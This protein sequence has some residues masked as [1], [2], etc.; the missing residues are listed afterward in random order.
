MIRLWEQGAYV[1][2]GRSI[3]PAREAEAENSHWRDADGQPLTSLSR[4]NSA[5]RTMAARILYSHDVNDYSESPFLHLR[6]DCLTSHDI[7]Y[8]SI[9]QT[10]RAIAGPD[11]P[12]FPVPYILSNCHNSLC[13]VGGTINADD[14]AFGLSAAKRY[15]AVFVPPHMAVIH[16]YIRETMAGCGKMILG[17]DS[18]TRYG[19]MGTLGVGEGGGELVK[20][21]LNRTYDIPI[22]EVIGVCL[23]GSPRPGTG[24][25][26]VA[27]TLIKAVFENGYV[28][29]KILEF[30]GDGIRN[31]S[32]DFRNAIDVMTTETACLSSIW[33]TDETVREYYVIHGREN[34]YKAM[35][36]GEAAYYN[37]LIEV[38]LSDI[39][40]MIALPF[41]PSHVYTIDELSRNAA[42]IASGEGFSLSAHM[43]NGR[44]CFNQGVIAG[45]AG[46]LYDN[47]RA[48]A[49]ILDSVSGTGQ[50]PLNIYPASQPIYISLAEN[51]VIAKLA[52]AGA[53]IKTAFCGPCFGAGDIPAHD[54]LSARHTTRNF[55]HREGSKPNDGQRAF[56]ALMDAR[57]IAATAKNGGILTAASDEGAGEK[58]KVPAYFFDGAAYA[59]RVY[60]GYRRANRT[61]A[62]T[63]GPGIR[64]WPAFPALAEDALLTVAAFITDPVTTTDELIPSGETSSYRSNPQALAEFTLSR[65]DPAYVARAKAAAD[66]QLGNPAWIALKRAFPAYRNIERRR[67][68]AIGS[69]IYAVKPGDGSAR[70]QAASCQRVLG[71]LANIAKE[72]ATKRYRSNLINW[73]IIPFILPDNPIFAVD[74]HIFIPGLQEAVKA[75]KESIAAYVLRGDEVAVF[76]LALPGLTAEEAEILLRGGLIN[77]MNL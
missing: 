44:I 38:G 22:P 42:D 69:L 47:I 12:A 23:T 25:Q 48:A 67:G 52:R 55:P 46:G 41:H 70:E 20:Q 43:E 65:K 72:Y 29:N 57:S 36:P 58:A 60:D 71:G 24:P 17:S 37:G 40:P 54:C 75:K 2:E 51:N 61:V 39:V 33:A 28:K 30:F 14:H 8:V 10:L 11:M 5:A 73:G 18:H 34:D 45:C 77:H 19:A 32:M 1:F 66:I 31:L 59:S 27:L 63:M 49:N 16:Q 68:I 6:F 4:Q 35:Q 56:V 3:V 21:L 9:I 26:D 15:G 53:I 50:F 74:D 76:T 7:T 64:D 13:A 62:L